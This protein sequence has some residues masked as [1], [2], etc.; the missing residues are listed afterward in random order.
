[1][2]RRTSSRIAGGALLALFLVPISLMGE[3]MKNQDTRAREQ[4]VEDWVAGSNSKVVPFSFEYDGNP[5]AKLLEAWSRTATTR[6]LDATRK[7]YTVNWLDR[8]TGLEIRY[9]V[10][11]YADFPVVEWTVYFKNKGS[12]DTPILA[13]IQVLDIALQHPVKE[14]L[15][16]HYI[17]GDGIASA[18]APRLASLGPG[19]TLQ[20]SPGGGRPTSGAFPYYNLEWSGQGTIIA[21]GWSGQWASSFVRDEAGTLRI[22]AGQELTHLKLHPGEEIRSPMIVQLFW[23]GGDWIEAQNQWRR[24]MRAHNTP[25]P[26]GK[27][28]APILAAG[29]A[30]F[31]GP[32]YSIELDNQSV[33]NLLI[34]KYADERLKLNY[35]WMDIYNSST[36]FWMNDPI[37]GSSGQYLAGSWDA[38]PKNYP[39]GLRGVSEYA[40]S[41]GMGLIVW[42][43]PEHVWPGYQFFKEHPEWLLS[44]P[45]DPVSRKA[46]N[47]GMPLG[48]RRV[49]NLGNQA[50]VNW[51][52]EHFSQTIKKEQISVYRQDFNIEPLVFWRNSDAPDRQGITENLYVQGYLQFWDGLLTHDPDL[53]IDTC[54]SGGRR[55]DIETLRRSVPLWRSDDS[56]NPVVEQNHTYGLALWVPYFGSGIARTDSYAFRSV[57]GSSLVASWD[58]RDK[59]SDYDNLRGLTAEFWRVAPYYVGD[60]YPLTQFT[61][62]KDN[63]IA[64]QFNRPE[65]GDG[66]VQAFFRDENNNQVEPPR[67][68]RLR[69][70]DPAAMYEV[71]DLDASA[72]NKFS[73]SRLMQEGLQVKF[74]TKPGAAVITYKKIG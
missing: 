46:I 5:N 39:N 3:A 70:L 11:E 54:A 31:G 1:M 26:G 42:Y 62:G 60:Y 67:N 16:L 25:R 68:L 21:V 69:G 19:A 72:P 20:F 61:F 52:I 74:L 57:L 64:W 27:D 44:A 38:D 9:V 41:K 6:Q 50:A 37:Y 14:D 51:L 47:Q 2:I 43:E 24:W 30:G 29:T 4:W 40:R 23:K 13:N 45:S 15:S 66:V 35:W 71:T 28:I 49:L 7:E 53:L 58:L 32:N 33:Q 55:D 22:R 59:K 36:N 63:W 73:G 17:D 12:A 48:N 65:Q 56:G 18:Y 10:V 34:R 8:R